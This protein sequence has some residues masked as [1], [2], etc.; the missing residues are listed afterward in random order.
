M[1][2]HNKHRTRKASGTLKKRK[3]NS[4]GSPLYLPNIAELIEQ[5]QITVGVIS[6]AWCIGATADDGHNTLAMLVRGER[7]TL[8]ELLTRLDKAI[9]KA[10]NEDII[11][12][13]I[14][15]P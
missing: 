4:A 15:T 10:Q 6:K 2:P 11:T 14:N 8:V 9:A 1:E 13:E 5:G 12:D 7:E 3:G